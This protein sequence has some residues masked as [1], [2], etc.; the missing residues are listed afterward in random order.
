MTKDTAKKTSI[1]ATGVALAPGL[2]AP[3]A[4]LAT[5]KYSIT[6]E[7]AVGENDGLFVRDEKGD[8][9]LDNGEPIPAESE[10]LMVKLVYPGGY[11]KN[12]QAATPEDLVSK[13]VGV[14][15]G[16]YGVP[17]EIK[18]AAL[19]KQLAAGAAIEVEV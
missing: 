19:P 16:R 15:R 6:F 2:A 4:G 1:A 14:L 12:H 10:H 9:V 18:I 5:G 11:T 13:V 17:S 3:A 7:S 8:L